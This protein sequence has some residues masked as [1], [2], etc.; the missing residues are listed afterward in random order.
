MT[1]RHSPGTRRI[2]GGLVQVI[3][4]PEAVELDLIGDLVDH[5]GL[6]MSVLPALFRHGLV[7]GLHAYDLGATVW[8]AA[9]GRRA[10]R[11]EPNVAERYFLLW[12]QGPTAVQRQF[13]IGIKRLITLAYYEHRVVQERL[14]YRPAAW[15]DQVKRRRLEMYAG[16]I[17]RHQHS[18]IA[19]DP[20][21]GIV[22]RAR[23]RRG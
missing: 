5:V 11:L 2:L 21:P 16:D 3:C 15:I 22:P 18:L 6:S 12:K 10:H 17:A 14:G 8:P 19:P 1:Y 9:R 20:L 4:P 7:L 23:R 13:V